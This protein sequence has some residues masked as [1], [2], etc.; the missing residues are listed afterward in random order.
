[1]T[2]RQAIFVL[3]TGVAVLSGCSATDTAAPPAA[4]AAPP[5]ATAADP[6]TAAAADC[7]DA[8]TKVKEYV[9]ST[10]IS[11]VTVNGQCTNVTIDTG[12][13]DDD[14]AAGKEIC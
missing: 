11:K 13:A 6:A 2:S 14:T 10:E 4:T 12:L 5:A 1:M 3:L 8:A 7:G 9:A